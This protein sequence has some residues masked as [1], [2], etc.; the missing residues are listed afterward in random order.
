MSSKYQFDDFDEDPVV[1]RGGHQLKEKG[2]QGQIVL[3]VSSGQLTDDINCC[4]LYTWYK[5]KQNLHLSFIS[6]R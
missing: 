6:S 4:W 2:G 5:M 3:R 1:G